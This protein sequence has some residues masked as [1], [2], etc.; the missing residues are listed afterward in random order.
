MNTSAISLPFSR[1]IDQ[2]AIEPYAV[3]ASHPAA[4]SDEVSGY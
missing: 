3:P 2:E 1:V 4:E